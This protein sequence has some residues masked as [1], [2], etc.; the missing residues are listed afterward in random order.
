MERDVGG[1]PPK[2]TKK[3]L[4]DIVEYTRENPIPLTYIAAEFGLRR[5]CIEEWLRTGSREYEEEGDS[6]LALFSVAYKKARNKNV[7]RLVGRIEGGK[8]GWQGSAWILERVFREEF[9]NDSAQIYEF[10]EMFNKLSE[11]FEEK[12]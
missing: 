10:K 11:K 3:L 7:N 8:I 12:K 4:N 2:Y 9:G 1:R 5:E 6:I